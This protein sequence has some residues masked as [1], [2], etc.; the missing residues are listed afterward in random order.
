[1]NLKKLLVTATFTCLFVA[2]WGAQTLW[3]QGERKN[4]A[5]SVNDIREVPV[6]FVIKT[7]RV[8]DPGVARVEQMGDRKLRVV[9]IKE[10]NTDLQVTGDGDVT[11]IFR[12]SIGSTLDA[13]LVEVRKDIDEIAGVEAETGLGKVVLRGTLTK[14]DQWRRLK[15]LMRSYGDKVECKVNFKIQDELLLKLKTD[16][17]KTGLK[18]LERGKKSAEPGYVSLACSDNNI[19]I[20]GSVCSRGEVEKINSLVCSYPWLKC[21][22]D[23]S[24]DADDD[25]YAVLNVSVAPVLLEV[26]VA[27]VGVTDKETDDMGANL[28]KNGVSF[29][30][31]IAAARGG[32]ASYAVNSG[33]N[34][35]IQA[36]GGSGPGRFK[37]VGHLTFKNDATEWKSYQD[38]GTITLPIMGANGGVGTQPIDYGLILKAKGGLADSENAAL[39]LEVELSVPI[40]QGQSPAGPIYDLKRSR[41]SST[42]QCP[43]GKTLIL[44][45]SKQLTEG[46]SVSGTPILSK[47]PLLS[48]LFGEKTQSKDQ[49]SVLIL[50]S[51]QIARAP[52]AA[53]PAVDQTSGTLEDANKPLTHFGDKNK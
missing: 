45:G 23:D 14:P 13:L 51:P 52:T 25:C 6:A 29:V 33:L 43:V 34:G 44:G 5:L 50:I 26:D 41:I 4:V 7:F 46:V 49:R 9:G 15:R 47:I 31:S 48:F 22:R 18:V 27:F 10:G 40:I 16:L 2:G 39:E 32:A 42:V 28:L 1:M 36:I 21:K 20:S 37:S 3:A 19:F 17:E 8:G 30:T 53:P 11:E 24:K 12:V 35:T 38:G